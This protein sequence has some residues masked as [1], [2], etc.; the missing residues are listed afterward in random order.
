MS[1]FIHLRVY[2][3][4]SLGSGAIR[5][6]DLVK[7][8]VKQKFPAL[9]LT[10]KN[11]LFASLEY[12]MEAL[13]YGVQPLVGIDICIHYGK[14]LYGNMVLIAKDQAG[15][16][17][18][19]KLASNV[20]LKRTANK[21]LSIDFGELLELESGLIVL[22][23]NPI[24]SIEKKAFSRKDGGS[25]EF[26][27]TLRQ[28]AKDRVYIEL[29]RKSNETIEDR[30]FEKQMVDYAYKN[31]IPLVATNYA[32]FLDPSF[33]EAQDALSCIS[34][35]RYILE[36]DRPRLA[37]DF[38]LKSSQAMCELFADI[39]EAVHN[40]INIAKRCTVYSESRPP[41]LPKFTQ[42]ISTPEEDIIRREA[43]DGLKRRL[44]DLSLN[45]DA[46]KEYFERLDFELS[47]I[48]KM[49]YAGYFLIVS[50]FIRWSK[51]QGIPVGPGRGSGAGSIVAWALEITDLDPIKFGLLFE[52]FLNPD[53][54]S[55]PD[56]DIDFCQERR[57]EVIEY[58]KHKYGS[59]K[60]A[61]II[62][63]GKL[64]A[65]AVLR[66][67][68]RVLH[69]P[70][71]AI[72]K[73]CKMVPNNPANPVTLSE[74]IKLDKELQKSQDTDPEI[75]K[76]LSISLQL[77]GINRHV[78]THAAG[79]VIADRPIIEI[80]PLYC[81]DAD[82][83]PAV[84]YSMKYAEAAGLI[85]FDFLGLKTLTVISWTL[86]LLKTKGIE[87]DISKLQLDDAPTYALLSKGA[88]IG[89]FQFESAG[90]KD[91]IKRLKPDAI[92]DLIALGSLYRPGPMDNIPNYIN[93]KHGLEKP[94]Y[95][96]PLMEN[97]LRETYGII[98][99]QEQVME[100]ARALAGYTL[101]NA[102]L[103]RRAM[104]KKIKAEMEAQREVFISGCVANNIDKSKAQEI[105][106]LIEKFA[107]YGFNKSHAAAYA[108][109][110]YQT[111]YLKANYTTEF[112]VASINSEIHDTDK[113]NIFLQEAKKFNI[114]ILLPDINKSIAL[115][116][117]EDGAIRFGLGAI[118]NVGVAV[119]NKVIEERK[120][121]L[122]KSIYDFVERCGKGVVNRRMF[123]GLCRSGAFDSLDD[124]RRKL[125]ESVESLLKY[126]QE[127]NAEKD[128]AQVGLFSFESDDLDQKPALERV[129]K[130][131][132]DEA[133]RNE[134][135]AF[136][137]YLSS[138]PL[139][140][141]SAKLKKL[142]VME[143]DRVEFISNQP[144]G[145]KI[146]LAGAITSRK[147]KSSKRGKYAFIQISDRRGLI[148]VSIFNEEMLYKNDELLKVGNLIFLTADVRSDDS[149]QRIM[150]DS[151]C[152]IEEALGRVNTALSVIIKSNSA[153]E[154][155]KELIGSSGKKVI[156]ALKLESGE[157]V[158]FNAA[159]ALCITEENERK[160]RRVNGVEV[161]EY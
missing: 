80:V 144:K 30:D 109:I 131:T 4:Y 48:N 104:G 78:S 51:E 89:V 108:I 96:H 52:R 71:G 136:G 44:S 36:E 91:A 32:S 57:E 114:P 118:K 121:G 16:T 6:K 46:E 106:A 82:G 76:L 158:S 105:F 74:A 130:W 157:L 115:F 18:L 1:S 35:G 72:D 81:D 155:V 39:P 53:R 128:S 24:D 95:L 42:D 156:L 28:K 77:E 34:G 107:S 47:V 69:M 161:V 153:I 40:T 8:S 2:S 27:D 73:I 93:R 7:S 160:L 68:G 84:Q 133:L 64:Q 102:D 116:S 87:L 45:K 100:I 134:F 41:L 149:G 23:A 33:Y 139:E 127:Y 152:S 58:V 97:C 3:D 55:M 19:L 66:D 13:K 132:I 61:Q 94:E 25:F 143:S 22:A 117:I 62:T 159:N 103:L 88:T 123:E 138:H 122:W 125:I 20:Y 63:Y 9:A 135:E 21:Q 92:E 112:L 142:G 17:N 26:L 113:I 150:V 12:S 137:F 111:A 15:Y 14:D 141:F 65:R 86:K 99:Y 147:V 145:T 75:N 49:F 146:T 101:G 90:M 60:V 5:I 31:N 67:V 38:Y 110:S 151:L 43:T 70:Y 37:S 10:D 54:V 98:V 148:E 85:K 140:P 11:N 126:S 120:K 29:I 50:D 119:V 59:D 124:N 56:F 83:M 154:E 79:V 129:E